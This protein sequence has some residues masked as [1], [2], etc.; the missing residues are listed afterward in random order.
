MLGGDRHREKVRKALR[1]ELVERRQS[2][3]AGDGLFA[4]TDFAAGDVVATYPGTW[5]SENEHLRR[6]RKGNPLVRFHHRCRDGYVE[7]DPRALGAHIGNHGCAP[8]GTVKEASFHD[9]PLLRAWR[10]IRAGEEIT[11]WY[12][13]TLPEP[14]QCLCR[15]SWCLGTIGWPSGFLTKTAVDRIVSIAER[16]RNIDMLMSLLALNRATMSQ[17]LASERPSAFEFLRMGTAQLLHMDE[18]F[19]APNGGQ[20]SR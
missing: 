16:N 18:L 10:D 17:Y 15:A 14:P 4:R 3:I 20:Q 13:W 2:A 5:I 7:P 11:Y 1:N 9:S 8:N 6:S 19:S 12:N